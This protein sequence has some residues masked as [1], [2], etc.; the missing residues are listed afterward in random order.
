MKITVDV[1]ANERYGFY[2]TGDIYLGGAKIG[3]IEECI[4]RTFTSGL[5]SILIAQP[6][7]YTC[8]TNIS[9]SNVF[10]AWSSRQEKN[11]G[12]SVCS[13]YK[14]SDGSI[15]CTDITPKC[16][17]YPLPI[18]IVEPL[19]ANFSF[20]GACPAANGSQ[21][22]SFSSSTTGGTPPVTYSWNFGDGSPAGS[23]ATPTHTYAGL[24]TYTVTLTV[25]DSGNPTQVDTQSYNVTV[26]SPAT[27]GIS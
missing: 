17:Y 23:G 9:L 19:T 1:N 3:A 8:G 16:F 14:N 20:A 5:Q 10:T 22:F 13:Y 4:D 15:N 24:G 2:I 6:I 7:H 25:T 11:V 18:D 26:T 27:A 12:V 21:V